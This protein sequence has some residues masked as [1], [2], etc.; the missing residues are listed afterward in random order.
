LYTGTPG[1][2][3][4]GT[5][6]GSAGSYAFGVSVGD[7]CC[8]SSFNGTNNPSTLDFQISVDGGS[9]FTTFAT[10]STHPPGDSGM[11]STTFGSFI[12]PGAFQFRIVD[13]NTSPSG[14]DFAIDDIN[15]SAVP[16]LSTWA[17][18]ILGFCGIGFMAHRRQRTGPRF[19]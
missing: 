3:G 16:E 7:I 6:I 18:L 17:M 10:A 1:T 13:D 14:N 15:I 9:T 4:S 12:A 2:L 19:A 5:N 8:N 11:F